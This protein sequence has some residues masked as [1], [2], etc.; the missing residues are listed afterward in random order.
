MLRRGMVSLSRKDTFRLR[1]TTK[2]DPNRCSND[3]SFGGR[4]SAPLALSVSVS[5][6]GAGAETLPVPEGLSDTVSDRTVPR[7]NGIKM[8]N[9]RGGHAGDMHGDAPTIFL[10]HGFP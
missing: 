1:T 3:P 8:Q 9:V 2:T 6:S 5:I 7:S 10:A 4:R